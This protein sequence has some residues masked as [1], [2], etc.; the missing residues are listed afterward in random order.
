MRWIIIVLALACLGCDPEAPETPTATATAVM[1]T[2]TA[3]P[4]TVA[5]NGP[6]PED[7]D[8]EYDEPGRAT[9]SNFIPDTMVVEC[10]D[11]GFSK[12]AVQIEFLGP[13]PGAGQDHLTVVWSVDNG[14]EIRDWWRRDPDGSTLYASVRAVPELIAARD[15]R[16][17]ASA[18]NGESRATEFERVPR[19]LGA[20][21]LL[22]PYG[23]SCPEPS[24]E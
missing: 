5:V 3:T 7:L 6:P 1:P 20:Y 10:A 11:D 8:W 22:G 24:A 17:V 18:D 21:G 2:P 13:L 4:Q 12:Y 16:L 14:F 9:I 23:L 15:I 19:P